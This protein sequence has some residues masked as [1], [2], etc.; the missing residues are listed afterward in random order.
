MI[1]ELVWFSHCSVVAVFFFVVVPVTEFVD[2][3]VCVAADHCIL[4]SAER[5]VVEH[6]YF[7][8]VLAEGDLFPLLQ[9]ADTV[10]TP[11]ASS[12]LLGIGLNFVRCN[13][14]WC[15]FSFGGASIGVFAML[16]DSYDLVPED[17][18]LDV[19]V[20]DVVAVLNFIGARS[21]SRMIFEHVAVIAVGG[22][23]E[24]GESIVEA[25]AD[26]VLDSI[27]VVPFR[28][29]IFPDRVGPRSARVLTSFSN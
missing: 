3:V 12:Q 23:L 21:G 19:L 26:S 9:Q 20:V 8:A 13:L 2:K 10:V 27:D 18:G 14:E 15:T 4:F 11:F 6:V 5:F 28:F 25:G 1:F 29:H 24:I 7:G 22:V 17:Y 16:S